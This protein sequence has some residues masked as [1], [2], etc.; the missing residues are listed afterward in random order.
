MN[1]L[2]KNKIEKDL[3]LIG[4]GHS[5]LNVLMSFI[6][7]PIPYIRITLVSNTIDTPYS[8]MLPGFIEGTYSWREVNIDLYKLTL[9]GNFRFINDDVIN[10]SGN[11]KIICFKERPSISFDFL[12]INCG[13]ESN[14]KQIIGA[15]KHTIPLKPISK[16]NFSWLENFKKIK[17]IAIIGGGAAGTEVSLA[18]RK[19]LNDKSIKIKIFTGYKGLLPNFNNISKKKITNILKKNDVKFYEN[20]PVKKITST[21]IIT[22]KNFKYKIDKVILATNGIAPNWLKKTD[23]TLCEKGFIITNN[24]FQ[25]NFE[26]IFAAGDVTNFNNLNLQKSG[27][28]AVKSGKILSGNIR[29]FILKG[30]LKQYLPQKHLLALI[31]LSNGQALANK[32][33]FSSTSKLNYKIKK[34]IDL[35][36]IQKYTKLNSK[37]S[38]K[39]IDDFMEC[40]GCAAKI[41]PEAIKKTL[42]KEIIYNSKDASSIPKF[43]KLFHTV[44]MI[45]SIITDPYKLGMISANHALS[46]IYSSGSYPISAQMILQLPSSN[47]EI[48]SRDIRQIYN[49]SKKIMDKNSCVINGGHTMIG[50]DYNPV[51]G[52]TI[53][54]KSKLNKNRKNIIYG[55]PLFLTGKIGSGLIFAGINTGKIDSYHKLEVID[56]MIEGNFRIGKI[57][58][59][60]NPLCCT[61]VTGFGLANHLINLINREKQSIGFNLELNKIATFK[62][63]KECL[64]RQIRSTFFEQNFNSAKNSIIFKN[65]LNNRHEILFDPQTVGGFLFVI[66]KG[67]I[68]EVSK[69]LDDNKVEYSII[70]SANN[71][72]PNINILQNG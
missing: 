25:T 24:Q 7:K 11:A 40:Q 3:V 48:H 42:P 49:G 66:S 15:K 71:N 58:N 59:K 16:L 64:K 44:D 20:E 41:S 65:N 34:L 53:I 55:D 4:G 1:F 35:R 27:V 39:K 6:K 9:M 38:N 10:L 22:D 45:S 60:I 61:D 56:H 31:G 52:F 69:L 32:L 36:F 54:G 28:Y 19:R 14:Y 30:K 62:G 23:L 47:D 57:L 8:G 12:S 51:I 43:P 17:S 50:Q 72:K 29:S 26:N 67:S 68:K 37:Q 2:Q 21:F 33:F 5:H 70:G 18:I 63:V 46:D 13:I